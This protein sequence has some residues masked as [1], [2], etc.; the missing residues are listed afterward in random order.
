MF[1]VWGWSNRARA[2]RIAIGRLDFTCVATDELARLAV[3][4]PII[5]AADG[6]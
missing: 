4:S 1:L 6:S 5:G 2:E 3:L